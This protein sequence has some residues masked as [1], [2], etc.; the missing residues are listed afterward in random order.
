MQARS[1]IEIAESGGRLPTELI[2]V[3]YWASQAGVVVYVLNGVT[4][5]AINLVLDPIVTTL[6]LQIPGV[7]YV[8]INDTARV[9]E[10]VRCAEEIYAATRVFRRQTADYGIAPSLIRSVAAAIPRLESRT[11]LSERDARA[12]KLARPHVV[13]PFPAMNR[14]HWAATDTTGKHP[15]KAAV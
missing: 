14:V 2:V 13:M 7:L 9:C 10:A 6:P 8:S 12:P 1:V 3:G 5:H 11:L 15:A 4:P